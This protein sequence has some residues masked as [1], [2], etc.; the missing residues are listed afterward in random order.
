MDSAPGTDTDAPSEIR[1]D[2]EQSTTNKV[3]VQ[4]S[5]ITGTEYTVWLDRDATIGQLIN[6]LRE[7]KYWPQQKDIRQACVVLSGGLTQERYPLRYAY[8]RFMEEK[9][10]CDMIASGKPLRFD[11]IWSTTPV[12]PTSLSWR[13]LHL[14]SGRG[15]V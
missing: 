3:K 14:Y 9:P 5:T 13:T 11:L 12:Q 7:Q 15:Y 4:I 10:V 1:S 2:P 6:R 8:V